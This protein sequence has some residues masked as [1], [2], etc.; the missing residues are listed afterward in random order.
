MYWAVFVSYEFT[1]RPWAYLTKA[2]TVT[3]IAAML[4]AWIII[5]ATLIKVATIYWL[6]EQ[7]YHSLVL[8]ALSGKFE[9]GGSLSFQTVSKH[10]I[11]IAWSLWTSWNLFSLSKLPIWLSSS[12][13]VSRRNLFA[14]IA[15]NAVLLKDA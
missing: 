6:S 3:L 7:V 5:I 14:L 11:N 4:S 13:E 15:L 9:C 12:Q 10:A 1:F 2:A 8:F